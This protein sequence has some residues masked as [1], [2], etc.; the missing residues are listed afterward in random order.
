[1]MPASRVKSLR[2]LVSVLQQIS[3]TLN[4]FGFKKE[5][6]TLQKV[7]KDL[8]SQLPVCGEDFEEA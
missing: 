3:R 5:S 1:M 6:A 8:Q 7:S 4:E 2:Y